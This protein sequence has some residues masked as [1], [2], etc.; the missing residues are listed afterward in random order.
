[1]TDTERPRLKQLASELDHYAVRDAFEDD[2]FCELI[3]LVTNVGATD[4]DFALQVTSAESPDANF[5]GWIQTLRNALDR[6]AWP[7]HDAWSEQYNI[8]G[9]HRMTRVVRRL[10]ELRRMA[11]DSTVREV[12]AVL[13]SL[14][15]NWHDM[16][17][18]ICTLIEENL[19]ELT[20]E[21]DEERE[22]IASDKR[23]VDDLVPPEIPDLGARETARQQWLSG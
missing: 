15:K 23:V 4:K 10:L 6:D 9:L 5:V 1:M 7:E 13:P 20:P 14:V 21:E 11:D 18:T 17:E 19:N 3:D 16:R 22:S 8:E 12:D 2:A